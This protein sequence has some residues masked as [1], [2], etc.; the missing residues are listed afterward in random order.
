MY[1]VLSRSKNRFTAYHQLV[2]GIS[3]FDCISSMAYILV[4]VLAPQEAGF[5]QSYGNDTTCKVQGF[6]IQLG[7]TSMFYN[8][9]LSLYFLLV[10]CFNWKERQIKIWKWV[11]HGAVLTVGFGMAFGALPFISA[12]FGVCGI[13]PP[14]TADQWQVSLFYT[15][16]VCIVLFILT[17][18]TVMICLYVYKKHRRV[19]KWMVESNRKLSLTRKVFWQSFWY[20]MAFYLTLPC[21]LV[22]FYVEYKSQHDFW[23]LVV[24]AVLAPLQGLMNALIYFQRSRGTRLSRCWKCLQIRAGSLFHVKG[25]STVASSAAMEKAGQA[26]VSGVIDSKV[27]EF[28]SEATISRFEAIRPPPEAGL[29]TEN[30]ESST[31]RLQSEHNES[32]GRG[33]ADKIQHDWWQTRLGGLRYD[34]TPD[35]EDQLRP[36]EENNH[37]GR[38]DE[39][40][41]VVASSSVGGERS[42]AFLGVVEYWDLNKQD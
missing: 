29:E 5:Y 17:A 19:R 4:G 8:L 36:Q 18:V 7:Q 32:S 30:A 6:M 21:V 2:L 26:V 24:A 15:A 3:I 31:F 20:V 22:T 34:G 37:P 25:S 9:C 16:P 27:C 39:A 38:F 11:V 33:S 23:L 1:D 42:S 35:W 28:G 41:T 40:T 10:V 14:L 12:Q 13:L